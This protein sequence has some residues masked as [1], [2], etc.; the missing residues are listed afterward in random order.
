MPIIQTIIK[1]MVDNSI[2]LASLL[3]GCFNIKSKIIDIFAGVSPLRILLV[4]NNARSRAVEIKMYNG[5]TIALSNTAADRYLFKKKCPAPGNI[6]V[7]S[8][9]A[10]VEFF[11]YPRPFKLPGIDSEIPIRIMAPDYSTVYEWLQSPLVLLQ[12]NSA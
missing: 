9:T 7:E 4:I 2:R 11:T 3:T 6:N 8:K 5:N 1:T 10:F 12:T